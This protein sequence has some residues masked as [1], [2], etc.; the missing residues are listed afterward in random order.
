MT[1]P[2]SPENPF[3]KAGQSYSPENP[4]SG[5]G[6]GLKP[7]S[8]GMKIG[9][10][11]LGVNVP[12]EDA[13]AGEVLKTAGLAAGHRLA[14]VPGGLLQALLHPLETLK[15]IPSGLMQTGKDLATAAGAGIH[16]V[17]AAVAPNAF[18]PQTKEDAL[19][20]ASALGRSAVD[21]GTMIVGGRAIGGFAR[22]VGE[23]MTPDVPPP[24]AWGG[25]PKMLAGPPETPGPKV[26]PQP[27]L[28]ATRDFAR[29]A[30]QNAPPKQPVTLTVSGQQDPAVINKMLGDPDVAAQV[31]TAVLNRRIGEQPLESP[32]KAFAAQAVQRAVGRGGEPNAVDPNAR[33]ATQTTQPENFATESARVEPSSPAV[34]MGGT[35][36]PPKGPI[37]IDAD[38]EQ[39]I[40][41]GEGWPAVKD[42]A[43]HIWTRRG[44]PAEHG[45]LMPWAEDE[46]AS[47]EKTGPSGEARG[48]LFGK[49]Y[50]SVADLDRIR[51]APMTPT[52]ASESPSQLVD[53][54]P[55][56]MQTGRG[57]FAG[58]G[59]RPLT[60]YEAQQMRQ[61]MDEH[62][63]K[64]FLPES[65]LRNQFYDMLGNRSGFIAP[66]LLTALAKAL[67]P[68]NLPNPGLGDILSRTAKTGAM[69]PFMPQ[70][71]TSLG[72]R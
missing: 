17:G 8:P 13:T 22:G 18:G 67:A 60:E 69:L 12:P 4:Y 53:R 21:L 29:D 44:Q 39:R 61:F 49:Q 62:P 41:N 46:G 64:G 2:F 71:D 55:P 7:L 20:G 65:E 45:D 48:W 28:T 72:I 66:Q 27:D 50:V 30:V 56:E 35:S 63:G 54:L 38:L 15:N 42:D 26:L 14:Q 68:K 51:N 9:E 1:V 10:P 58:P 33:I 59:D 40:A 5:G 37:P 32:T 3:A 34:P 70:Q 36:T 23:G 47:F 57:T 52:S 16:S 24:P 6:D 25:G 43:G 31:R 19:A 11:W